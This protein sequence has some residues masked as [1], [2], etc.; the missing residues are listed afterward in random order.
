[1]ADTLTGD[2]S[3]HL[4][5][6]DTPPTDPIALLERW[7]DLAGHPASRII[8]VK[9]VVDRALLFTTHVNSRKGQHLAATPFAAMTVY[10]RETLQQITIAGPVD[11]LPDDQSSALFDGRPLAA[12]ATTAVS[13]QSQPLVDEQ[14]L[15]QHARELIDT[16]APLTRPPGWAGYRLVP[17]TIEFWQG[18]SSRLHRRLEY[19]WDGGTWSNHRLQP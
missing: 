15:H 2:E 6:F 12:Q 4:P 19:T 7:L 1:V 11:Q 17:H 14:L 5:E 16:G 8:L 10:W 18:R 3:L 9:G 13:H